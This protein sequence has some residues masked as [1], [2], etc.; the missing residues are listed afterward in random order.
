MPVT[1]T[2]EQIRVLSLPGEPMRLEILTRKYGPRL[3]T[4]LRIE[5]AKYPNGYIREWAFWQTSCVLCGAPFEIKTSAIA[6]P[7]SSG[8]FGLV[9]CPTHRGSLSG[10]K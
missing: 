9:T 8:S 1:V 5:A 4:R 2:P 7:T 6:W 10:A 3:F